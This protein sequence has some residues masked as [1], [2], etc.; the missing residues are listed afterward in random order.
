MLL[1]LL[2]TSNRGCALADLPIAVVVFERVP[3]IDLPPVVVASSSVSATVETPSLSICSVHNVQDSTV[4]LRP[5]HTLFVLS[6]PEIP[7]SADLVE[8]LD[9]GGES[10]GSVSSDPKLSFLPS[11]LASEYLYRHILTPTNTIS[12]KA[13][14]TT[15][16]AV[17]PASVRLLEVPKSGSSCIRP[18]RQPALRALIAKEE[19]VSKDPDWSLYTRSIAEQEISSSVILTSSSGLRREVPDSQIPKHCSSSS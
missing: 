19:Q 2:K 12:K 18:H 3:R 10:I 4:F 14:A 13:A 1:K 15:S 6:I 7:L 8:D 11:P 5:F 17:Y 9:R 16:I